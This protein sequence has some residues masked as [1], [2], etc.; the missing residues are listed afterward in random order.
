LASGLLRCGWW[1][2][3]E[4]DRVRC[5]NELKPSIRLVVGNRRN[6]RVFGLDRCVVYD[7]NEHCS[8]ESDGGL[9][10]TG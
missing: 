5:V 1:S 8:D 10:T 2:K 4:V 7:K 3:I 6:S 9:N